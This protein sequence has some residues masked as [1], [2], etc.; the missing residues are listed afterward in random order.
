MVE[1]GEE[2]SPVAFIRELLM[3]FGQL[4]SIATAQLMRDRYE[5]Y[6]GIHNH[7]IDDG[8]PLS[9]V[10]YREAEDN[11]RSS[12]LYERITEFAKKKVGKHLHISLTE[13]MNMPRDVCDHLIKV[14]TDME[15]IEQEMQRKALLGLPDT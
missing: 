15:T 12:R 1:F 11:S 2:K 8:D 6:Y 10:A 5:T 13:F 7:D 14:A 4:G 9:L 3:T